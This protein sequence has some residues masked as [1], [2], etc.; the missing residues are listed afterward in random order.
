[1]GELGEMVTAFSIVA[2]LC[3]IASALIGAAHSIGNHH[4][5]GASRIARRLKEEMDSFRGK[6]S[7]LLKDVGLIFVLLAAALSVYGVLTNG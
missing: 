1:M 2:G 5:D 7:V 4:V 3:L 6:T